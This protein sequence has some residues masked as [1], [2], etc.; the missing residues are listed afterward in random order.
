MH[1]AEQFKKSLTLWI[2]YT[3]EM[4]QDGLKN[5]ANALFDHARKQRGRGH[6]KNITK[7][8][9]GQNRLNNLFIFF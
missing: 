2:T 9:F 3:V 1:I 5:T 7:K 4:L 8:L 6:S